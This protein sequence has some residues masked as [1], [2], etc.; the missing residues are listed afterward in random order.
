MLGGHP[1][2]NNIKA[3][4]TQY[5]YTS[6]ALLGNNSLQFNFGNGDVGGGIYRNATSSNVETRIF[7]DSVN[8][9]P[10]SKGSITFFTNG[11]EKVRID[12]NGNLGIGNNNPSASLHVTGTGRFDNTITTT[13]HRSAIRN[14]TGNT[15][16]ADTD[17]YIFASATGGAVTVTLPSASGRDGQTYT[18]KKTD[19]SSNNVTV[20]T[21]SS[22]FIDGAN[23][24]SLT[25]QWM[26]V[27]IVANGGNWMIV[28]K[29]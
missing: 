1:A 10:Y 22:Q 3:K 15:S 27:I 6:S 18:I 17:E 12:P 16:I 24:Y 14:I 21:S 9:Y 26:Y 23:P 20:A 29:N 4:F 13:G 25:T 28:A 2:N 7:S 11:T 8:G 19:N 5:N